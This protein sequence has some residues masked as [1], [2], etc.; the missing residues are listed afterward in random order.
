VIKAGREYTNIVDDFSDISLKS[1]NKRCPAIIFADNRTDKVIGR[2]IFLTV[3]INTMNDA[4]IIGVPLG[5][6]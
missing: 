5:T 4:N 1:V 2:I 3:S 6:R